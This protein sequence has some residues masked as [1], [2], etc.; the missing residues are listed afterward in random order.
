MKSFICSLL[1]FIFS[2]SAY[3][4]TQYDDIISEIIPIRDLSNREYRLLKEELKVQSLIIESIL[5]IQMNGGEIQNYEEAASTLQRAIDKASKAKR[6]YAADHLKGQVTNFIESTIDTTI[7][8]TKLKKNTNRIFAIVQKEFQKK[9]VN[10]SSI[11]RRFGLQVGLFYLAAVQVDYTIPLILM[12]QG[13]VKLG[14]TL[15]SLPISIT[16]TAMFASL[17]NTVKYRH[18]IKKLGIKESFNQYKIFRKIRRELGRSFFGETELIKIKLQGKSYFF[19]VKDN[20]LISRLLVKMGYN[21]E[22]NYQSLLAYFHEED[23]FRGFTRRIAQSG[24]AEY[25][26]LLKMILKIEKSGTPEMLVNLEKRFKHKVNILNGIHLK[27]QHLH[28]ILRAS[29]VKDFD[30]FFHVL[31]HVPRDMPP[32]VLDNAFKNYIF[33]R[34]TKNIDQYYSISHFK[35][36]NNLNS[37]YNKE[38]RP[39]FA[40]R[41]DY[42]LNQNTYDFIIDQ[43]Y[44]ALAPVNSCGQVYR[45]KKDVFEPAL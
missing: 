21:K 19:T 13:N 8:P 1:F 31:K 11:T 39:A 38:I 15:M 26:K 41:I 6:V 27:E 16:S 40:K 33:P 9:A 7:N 37:L 17:R 5:E 3:T 12:A 22:L 45:F 14:A 23:L 43:V 25:K 35:A 30:E 36:F 18:L 42:H 44:L 29:H 20:G 24:E 2:L 34:M 10:I 32:T 28:W 4:S